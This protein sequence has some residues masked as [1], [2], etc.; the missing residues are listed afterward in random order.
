MT[1]LD[2]MANEYSYGNAYPSEFEAYKAGALA[3]LD[4]MQRAAESI[5]RESDGEVY[6]L[7]VGYL[8]EWVKKELEADHDK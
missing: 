8:Y 7:G 4:M 2:K 1:K 5:C 3:A 6:A